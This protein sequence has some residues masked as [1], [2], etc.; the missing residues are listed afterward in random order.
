MKTRAPITTGKVKSASTMAMAFASKG[1]ASV[2]A[3]DASNHITLISR[4]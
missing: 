2:G 1:G 4:R 3:L